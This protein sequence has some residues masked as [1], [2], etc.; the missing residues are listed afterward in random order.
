MAAASEIRPIENPD[1]TH[2]VVD[3]TDRNLQHDTGDVDHRHANEH[4]Q[5]RTCTYPVSNNHL[6]RCWHLHEKVKMEADA[7]VEKKSRPKLEPQITEVSIRPPEPFSWKS[8]LRINRDLLPLKFTLFFFMSSA[9]ALLP[10][11]TIHMK[12]IGIKTEHIAIMYAALPFTIFLAP[13]T[14]GFLADKMGSYTRALIVTIIGS[15]IFHTVLL[16]LPPVSEV[17]ASPLRMNFTMISDVVNLEWNECAV[18]D[19]VIFPASE[20][21]PSDPGGHA[22]F[23]NLGYILSAMHF[24]ILHSHA[25][26][27]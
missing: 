26:N 1:D 14:V 17:S 3:T 20:N 4:D 25:K 18:L 12:D 13:P 9:V 16:F 7:E 5:Y 8:C 24:L 15:G 2:H 6:P 27:M 19:E 22:S 10:Y 23:A 11:L 21:C